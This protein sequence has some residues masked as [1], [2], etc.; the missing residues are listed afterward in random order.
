MNNLN[1]QTQFMHGT[2]PSNEGHA[3]E[4]QPG[5]AHETDRESSSEWFTITDDAS[6][7][8]PV[9]F[10]DDEDELDPLL[11]G[12]IGASQGTLPS[13]PSPSVQQRPPSSSSQHSQLP[14]TDPNS[15]LLQP[16]Q[17]RLQDRLSS[18]L[19]I[20]RIRLSAARA[21]L[22]RETA[23]REQTGV[24]LYSVL[25]EQKALQKACIDVASEA[26]GRLTGREML[27]AQNDV[28]RRE[29]EE[30]GSK[31]VSLKSQLVS[32]KKQ[33]EALEQQ[34]KKQETELQVTADK[35]KILELENASANTRSSLPH[36]SIQI[37]LF[38]TKL[39]AALIAAEHRK[40]LL[41]PRLAIATDQV[42]Q[43]SQRLA[44]AQ[45]EL[46]S[47]APDVERTEKSF[48]GTR[49]KV[50]SRTA[51]LYALEAKLTGKM[52]GIKA[53]ETEL[54][55]LQTEA[56]KVASDRSTL[57]RQF[58]SLETSI[59]SARIS[60]ESAEIETTKLASQLVSH[61]LQVSDIELATERATAQNAQLAKQFDLLDSKSAQLKSTLR[62][63]CGRKLPPSQSKHA[64]RLQMRISEL[65][66]RSNA[67]EKLIQLA[68]T[69]LVHAEKRV[70]EALKAKLE[71]S[72][73]ASE[74]QDRFAQLGGEQRNFEK[75]LEA[76]I[77]A[78]SRASREREKLGIELDK[79]QLA[80]SKRGE[81]AGPQRTA[82]AELQGQ[83]GKTRELLA[84]HARQHAVKSRELEILNGKLGEVQELAYK[85]REK[86]AGLVKE[87]DRLVGYVRSEEQLSV[88]YSRQLSQL[89]SALERT[90][91]ANW[92]ATLLQDSLQVKMKELEHRARGVLSELEAKATDLRRQL[93]ASK[94][95][96]SDARHVLAQLGVARGLWKDRISSCEALVRGIDPE[97][98]QAEIVVLQKEVLETKSKLEKLVETREKVLVEL[99]RSVESSA[100]MQNLVKVGGA[101]RG[102]DR[103]VAEVR[104]L[105]KGCELD[106]KKVEGGEFFWDGSW[107]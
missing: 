106:W 90:D 26:E 22:A 50:T 44:Q 55:R 31:L 88:E 65:V 23:S 9:P 59:E 39:D 63:L 33:S 5:H 62:T 4:T 79:L 41:E 10:V 94:E 102:I 43:H 29:R 11:R 30:K 2:T 1:I 80:A 105:L 17:S 7:P 69:E 37:S 73:R 97:S 98:G 38:L 45:A 20:L 61:K 86:L 36:Q 78:V 24:L 49:E 28:Q 8:V 76:C 100:A 19:D 15:T 91:T 32:L 25:A 3:L 75:Q 14:T 54:G 46:E 77:N 12:T 6:S 42:A 83:L 107:E 87:R 104:A 85:G 68:T 67:T 16:L 51:E 52:E 60:L 21:D 58:S 81:L 95:A 89:R 27:E 18:T 48:H 101:Q 92:Q 72:E 56:D 64:E 66:G 74:M 71:A 34:N 82:I 99:K 57:L 103:K 35:L 96:H 93:A 40:A 13:L 47:L 84:L 53:K 70:E